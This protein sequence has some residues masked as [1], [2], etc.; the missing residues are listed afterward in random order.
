ADVGAG[1]YARAP[2]SADS[3]AAKPVPQRMLIAVGGPLFNFILS[4]V[5]LLILAV[6]G[7]GHYRPILNPAPDSSLYT[8][9]VRAGDVIVSIDDSPVRFRRDIATTAIAPIIED[10]EVTITVL[11]PASNEELQATLRHP[12]STDSTR[13]LTEVLAKEIKFLGPPAIVGNIRAGFPAAESSLR[14]GDVVVDVDGN[15]VSDFGDLVYMVRERPNQTLTL[16]VERDDQR[17]TMSVPTAATPGDASVGMLGVGL[18]DSHPDYISWADSV[19]AHPTWAEVPG[20]A[21]GELWDLFALTWR[22]VIWLITGSVGID[23]LKGPIGI[24]DYA[25]NSLEYG[26]LPFLHF[27]ALISVSIGVLNLLPIP[28]LDGGHILLLACEGVRGRPVPVAVETWLTWAGIALVGSLVVI[29]VFNDIYA[30]L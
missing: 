30:L 21:L 11:R 12:T 23:N 28:V 26:V 8:Q 13:F 29:T 9:G 2:L 15:P 4:G 10:A 6:A 25:G 22:S 1:A 16:I 5:L 3:Y 27:I 7:F 14:L 20:I 17:L 24:A 18:D 19:R